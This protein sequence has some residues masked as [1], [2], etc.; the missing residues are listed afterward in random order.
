MQFQQCLILQDFVSDLSFGSNCIHKQAFRGTQSQLCAKLTQ[1]MN[2][3]NPED[4]WTQSW[5]AIPPLPAQQHC[6]YIPHIRNTRAD[7]QKLFP[8]NQSE[9]V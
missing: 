9:E 1:K 2:A 3:H 6:H 7:F 8:E 5:T 4:T